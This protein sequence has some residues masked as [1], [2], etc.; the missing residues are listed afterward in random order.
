VTAGG[1]AR[2]FVAGDYSH[3]DVNRVLGE[4]DETILTPTVSEFLRECL[5]P[6]GR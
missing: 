3:E 1:D 4:A 6:S 5:T 2:L